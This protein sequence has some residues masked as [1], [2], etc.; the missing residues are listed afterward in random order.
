MAD[1]V[2]LRRRATEGL[3]ELRVLDLYAGN[4]VLWRNFDT[5]RYYGV[6]IIPGKG[7]NLNADCRRVIASLDLSGFNVIDCDS[8]G[9]PFDV[10]EAIFANSTLAAGTVVIFT[11]ISNKMSGISRRCLDM[12][13]LS[14]LSKKARTPVNGLGIELFYAALENWGVREVHRYRVRGSY[15]K[16]YG[17]F[18]V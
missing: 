12:F 6:E 11:A 10:I 9:V 7:S 1:K 18:V 4:N 15:D 5:A 2:F 3:R 8:Y 13:G 17:Y 16:H 14:A